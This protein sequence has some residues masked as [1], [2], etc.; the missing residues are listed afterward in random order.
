LLGF[1]VPLQS[2]Q[3]LWVNL[4]THGVPG[5]AIGNEPA[6]A[7]V[8][9]RPPR[10]PREQLLDARTAGRVAV[11]GI[12][13][14]ITCTL[15]AT[16]ARLADRPWQSVLFLSLA[17]CQ[18]A[19]ALALRPQG[20][21]RGRNPLLMAAVAVNVV[22]AWLAVGWRPLRELLRTDPIEPRDLLPCLAAAAVIA[23][24]AWLQ[25]RLATKGGVNHRDRA[26]RD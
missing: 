11:L 12:S 4:L 3:I 13:I 2:G 14:A 7:D 5:V 6:A 1:P 10:P 16:Y 25:I 9:R 22:L 19:A 18:L 23:V 26:R 17:G 15:A 21:H 24:V 8:F 20:H